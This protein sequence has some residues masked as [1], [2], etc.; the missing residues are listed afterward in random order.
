[1]FQIYYFFFTEFSFQE[2]SFWT[3]KTKLILKMKNNVEG[4][5]LLKQHLF[6]WSNII[7]VVFSKQL[8]LNVTSHTHSALISFGI[9]FICDFLLKSQKP[10]QDFIKILLRFWCLLRL[11]FWASSGVI[12]VVLVGLLCF[13]L[14]L[15]CVNI[16][17]LEFFVTVRL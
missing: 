13:S 3:L 16:F 5:S 7:T 9:E 4:D 8:E 1:M 11:P 17:I 2:H 14:L 6:Y 10:C 15:S 12:S